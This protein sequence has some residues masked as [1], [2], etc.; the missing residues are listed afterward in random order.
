M[1]SYTRESDVV[2]DIGAS[3]GP[4]TKRFLSKAVKGEVHVFEP[5]PEWCEALRNIA[6]TDHYFV[7]Q[8][9]VGAVAKGKAAMYVAGAGKNGRASIYPVFGKKSIEVDVRSLDDFV[10]ETG[11]V[12]NVVKID[13]EG[14]E[15][16]VLKGMKTILGNRALHVVAVEVHFKI[17]DRYAM[18]NAPREIVRTLR[19]NQFK[20]GWTDASHFIAVR[21]RPV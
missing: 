13:V 21:D 2:Y 7:H 16:E 17:L 18:R 5:I 1:L 10:S 20:V 11:S 9:A 3:S 8:F 15:H 19:E 12:P 6:T 14:Y 4:Y